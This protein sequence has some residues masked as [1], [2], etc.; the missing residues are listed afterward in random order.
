MKKK[1]AITTIVI[2]LGAVL[3]YLHDRAKKYIKIIND[4]TSWEDDEL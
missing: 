4:G 2:I 3:V 1:T